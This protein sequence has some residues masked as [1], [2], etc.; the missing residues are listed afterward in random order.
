MTDPPLSYSLT[1]RLMCGSACGLSLPTVAS[2]HRR[3][4]H[5][6][7]LECFIMLWK[8]SV[9]SIDPASSELPD[10]YWQESLVVCVWPIWILTFIVTVCWINAGQ[11]QTCRGELSLT[12]PCMLIH[13][14]RL[15]NVGAWMS[16]YCSYCKC[17]QQEDQLQSCWYEGT[18][19]AFPKYTSAVNQYSVHLVPDLK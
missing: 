1:A 8:Q 6:R 12:Q 17:V 4:P 18:K 2:H 11:G 7:G 16:C 14:S 15:S 5:L 13:T 9:G 3:H 19:C 10:V